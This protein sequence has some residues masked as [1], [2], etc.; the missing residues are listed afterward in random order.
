MYVCKKCHKVSRATDLIDPVVIDLA[1]A[2]LA[3]PDA[4]ELLVDRSRAD[5]AELRQQERALLEQIDTLAVDY[6]EGRFNG[7]QVKLVTDRL[8]VK[9]AEVR[10]G[11]RDANKARVFDGL[12]GATNLRKV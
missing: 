2:F 3:S 7:R 12:V 6:A 10:D 1:L 4:A 8:E 5:I 9:L 11:M